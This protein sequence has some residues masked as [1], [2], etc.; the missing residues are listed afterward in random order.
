MPRVEIRSKYSVHIFV[1]ELS[2][3][4]RYSWFA[5]DYI[6]V[7]LSTALYEQILDGSKA[8]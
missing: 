3:G 8:I 5:V 7:A 6:L 4:A 2:N 1:A